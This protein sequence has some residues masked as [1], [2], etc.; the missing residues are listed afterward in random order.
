M[1][2]QLVREIKRGDDEGAEPILVWSTGVTGTRG[3]QP[4]V[5]STVAAGAAHGVNYVEEE[6]TR[7]A[8]Q[9]L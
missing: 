4:A 2:L 7:P 6:D 1:L 3:P 9:L 8:V 5:T